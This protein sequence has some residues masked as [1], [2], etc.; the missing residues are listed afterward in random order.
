[1][2]KIIPFL[3]FDTEAIEAMNFYT[4]IFPNTEIH[5]VDTFDNSGATAHVNGTIDTFNNSGPD[6]KTTVQVVSFNICG[7]EV[8]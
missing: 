3:W 4:S 5:S 6:E 1:M 2:Q 7:L 8:Q